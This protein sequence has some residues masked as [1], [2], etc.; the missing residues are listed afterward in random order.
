MRKS[1]GGDGTAS[2]G[3][4]AL[5]GFVDVILELR[6]APKSTDPHG[7][8]RELKAYGRMQGIPPEWLIELDPDSNTYRVVSADQAH[9]AGA[10]AKREKEE[11]RKDDLRHAILGVLPANREQA[12]TRDEIWEKL[13]DAVRVNQA[14]CWSVL[15]AEVPNLW[16][17]EGGGRKAGAYRY[18]RTEDC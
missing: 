13:P 16:M 14:R 17:K 15:E 5:A 18:W 9:G 11:G 6:R 1:D 3:S 8:R 10:E 4:G 7:I 12:M 2:R